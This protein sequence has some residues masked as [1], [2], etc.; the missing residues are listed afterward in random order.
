VN[1]AED[2]LVIFA[3][4]PIPGKVKTRLMPSY[5]AEEACAI[6]LALLRDVI[7]GAVRAVGGRAGVILAWSEPA[8]TAAALGELAAGVRVTTQSGGDLGERMALAIQSEIRA[9]RKRVV[10][11]G[12]DAPTLPDDHL[13]ASFDALHKA[14]VV[15]GPSRD[16]G[17]YLIGMSRLHL[18]LFRN[19]RWGTGEVLGATRARLKKAGISCVELGSWHD[20]DTPEDIGRL[21]KELLHMKDRRA[22]AIPPRTYRTLARLVPGRI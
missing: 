13:A 3:R 8:D 5:S 19:M 2:S 7:E 21:W 22:P 10:I 9:G 1:D 11:L 14:D 12:S 17:Y 16:G 18:P 4:V 15:I 6:H 20:V